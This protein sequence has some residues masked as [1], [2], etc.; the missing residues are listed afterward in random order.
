MANPFRF[1]FGGRRVRRRDF[2]QPAG[3]T[4]NPLFPTPRRQAGIWGLTF[5]ILA[6]VAAVLYVILS[7]KFRITNIRV[8]G[9]NKLGAESIAAFM[10]SRLDVSFLSLAWRRVT[11]LTPVTSIERELRTAIEKIVTLDQLVITRQ[12]L[13]T[14][15]VQLRELT[16]NLVWSTDRGQ[17]F[18]L[19]HRGIVVEEIPGEPPPEF[20]VVSDANSLNLELGQTALK[21]SFITFLRR[22]LAE[23]TRLSIEPSKAST[24]PVSCPVPPPAEDIEETPEKNLNSKN[25]NA[26]SRPPFIRSN[27]NSTNDLEKNINPSL[28]Q[29]LPTSCSLM[30]LAINEPTLVITTSEGW[31]LRL[32]TSGNVDTQLQKMTTTLRD[33]LKNNRSRLLYLDV[34]FGDRVFYQQR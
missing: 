3:P 11:F 34:R 21:P 13:N 15:V 17:Y 5:V 28:K 33:H 29:T 9:S 7:P 25:D 12:G 8:E 31:D 23:L 10:N 24:W 19:D 20:P 4:N 26:N 16:P 22:V 14:L 30:E 18:F 1:L 2:A 27:A 32:D 6:I